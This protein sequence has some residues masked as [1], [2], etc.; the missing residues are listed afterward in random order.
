MCKALGDPMRLRIFAF[1][2]S[3]SGTVALEGSGAVRRLQGP[4][5]GEICCHVTGL[6]KVTSTVSFH[7]KELRQAGLVRTERQGKHTICYVNDEQV[8][9]LCRYLAG[10]TNDQADCCRIPRT[11][12]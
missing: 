1:L 10:K 8:E 3:C 2:R 4:T 9:E 12:P 11:S 6:S 5:V 7:L